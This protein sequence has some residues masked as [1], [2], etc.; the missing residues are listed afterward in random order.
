MDKRTHE[1]K[2]PKDKKLIEPKN[3]KGQND[4]MTKQQKDDRT[5]RRRT[6]RITELND[7]MTRGLKYERLKVLK[8]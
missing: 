5:R 2:R 3:Y 8:D 4:S 7:K 1:K 6:E